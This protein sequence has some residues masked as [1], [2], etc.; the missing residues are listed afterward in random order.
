M[1]IDKRD[2]ATRHLQYKRVASAVCL[3]VSRCYTMLARLH[4]T[5]KTACHDSRH[6]VVQ[7][8]VHLIH[9]TPVLV[10]VTVCMALL[11]FQSACSSACGYYVSMSRAAL[12]L[13]VPY[14]NKRQP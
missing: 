6:F 4:V 1:V 5:S 14:T 9:Q 8:T 11:L 13:Q 2:D 10:V 12:C 7:F 3:I